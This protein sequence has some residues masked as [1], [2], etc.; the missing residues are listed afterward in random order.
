MYRNLDNYV[1]FRW[2]GLKKNGT[3]D[4]ESPMAVEGKVTRNTFF[5]LI[6]ASNG[7]ENYSFNKLFSNSYF[8][9]FKQWQCIQEMNVSGSYLTINA[10]NGYRNV[11]NPIWAFIVFQTNKL[12]NQEKDNNTFVHANVRNF[13]IDHNGRRYP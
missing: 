8:F 6:C 1:L 3:A 13:W 7:N 10:A 9:E 11:E 2:K 5:F 12:K 4:S